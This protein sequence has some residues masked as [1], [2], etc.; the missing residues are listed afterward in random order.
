[1]ARTNNNASGSGSGS[2]TKK[3]S[4]PLNK[5]EEEA[6]L[7]QLAE[8]QSGSKDERKLV[9]KTAIKDAKLV[10]PK[11]DAQLLKQRRMRKAEVLEKT[12]A[13]AG[14]KE[15]IGNYQHAL[16]TIMEGLSEEELKR[17]G[18]TAKEWANEGPP[19][20]VQVEV[21]QK[22]SGNIMR[23]FADK[24]F[25]DAGM[26][27]TILWAY[28]DNDGDL[29]ANV[30]D[31]NEDLDGTSFMKTRDL[32]PVLDE[33]KSYVREE[34]DM[35]VEGEDDDETGDGRPLK[36]GGNKRARK[37]SYSIELDDDGNPIIPDF[38]E[39]NLDTKKAIIRAFL[40]CHYRICS[41]KPKVA[42]PWSAARDN[43]SQF[44][45]GLYLPTDVKIKDPSKLQSSEADALLEYWY[46]RQTDRVGETF[47]FKGWMD[48]DKEFRSPVGNSG[49]SL[50]HE[51]EER[52]EPSAKGRSAY[53]ELEG[54]EEEQEAEDEDEDRDE[55]EDED[56]I[57]HA[58]AKPMAQYGKAARAN[59]VTRTSRVEPSAH[60]D[61][62]DDEDKDGDEDEDDE[63]EGEDE[64]DVPAKRTRSKAAPSREPQRPQG[65]QV[66]R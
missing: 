49:S 55:E 46:E 56:E 18:E 32:S 45:L 60:D 21:T 42:V 54:G 58:V 34:F 61:D 7:A 23:E 66:K 5:A 36:T 4:P 13:K 6:L 63:D 29:T 35:D 48:K 2:N 50:G 15:M 47:T 62:D 3:K 65:K 39:S 33:W 10:A 26:R 22:R 37:A 57:V 14:D 16:R 17:A 30:T 64:D 38:S 43:K 1:M 41:G 9:L 20:E 51:S 24:L 59:M 19:K 25:K 53:K 28:K 27:V 12:G 52:D 44:I 8:W 40:T 31:F 11:M